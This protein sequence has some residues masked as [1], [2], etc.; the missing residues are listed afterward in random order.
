[1]IVQRGLTRLP[2]YT[3]NTPVPDP[4]PQQDDSGWGDA[5]MIIGKRMAVGALIGAGVGAANGWAHQ[6]GQVARTATLGVTLVGAFLSG[7]LGVATAMLVA[8]PGSSMVGGAIGGAMMGGL[9]G[10]LSTPR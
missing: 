4:P 6:A 8:N 2:H 3:A 5:V 7:T 1:M 9:F 10:L